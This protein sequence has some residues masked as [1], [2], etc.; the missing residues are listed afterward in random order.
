VR[1]QTKVIRQREAALEERYRDLFENANDILYTLNVDG[2]ITSM[3]HSGVTVFGLSEGELLGR[4]IESLVDPEDLLMMRRQ[5][6]SKLAGAPRTTYELRLLGGQG[7]RITL[8]VNSRLIFRDGVPIG[9]QGIARDITERKDAEEALR[10]SE[11]QLRV[12]LEERERLGR[13]LHDSII[14]SIYAAGLNLD[15]CARLTSREPASVEK[16]LTKITADLNQVIREVRGFIGKL[17]RNGVS[18]NEFKTALTSMALSYEEGGGLE[19]DLQIEDDAM[20]ELDPASASQLL[21]IA[22]EA[23]G[24]AARHAKA[25]F[26]MVSLRWRDETVCFEVTDDGI[27]F[28]PV[29]SG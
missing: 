1:I 5:R 2:E 22:R 13:D 29:V 19:I 26:L 14:Q 17:E 16:R 20:R 28:D 3:N 9:I 10:A 23:I 21:N 25:R 11:Q 7:Q 18:G 8:E 27:G 24:N 15:D 6:E 4:N 12:S